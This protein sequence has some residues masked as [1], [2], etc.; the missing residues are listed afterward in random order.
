[1]ESRT[2]KNPPGRGE[3]AMSPARNCSLT[4]GGREGGG[5]LG[6]REFFDQCVV[7]P[8][9]MKTKKNCKH[10]NL[11]GGEKAKNIHLTK[12]KPGPPFEWRGLRIKT[13]TE[14]EDP[15]THSKKKEKRTGGKGRC[16]GRPKILISPHK[17][18]R[19]IR[20]RGQSLPSKERRFRKKGSNN[21]NKPFLPRREKGVQS[22]QQ[23][24]TQHGAKERE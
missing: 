6:K 13:T 1:M 8:A 4:E 19:E 14:G 23:T 2:N 15:T 24:W 9:K 18:R 3:G 22:A 5:T 20:V 10:A 16:E 12:K 21:I 7:P 17:I 11:G